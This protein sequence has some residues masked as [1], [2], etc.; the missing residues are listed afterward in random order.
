MTF[1]EARARV[2]HGLMPLPTERVPLDQAHGRALRMDVRAP[3]ALPPFANSAMDGIAVRAA[4]LAGASAGAPVTLAI[5]DTIAAGHPASR[6]LGAGQA[7]RIMTGAPLPEGA[8][9][10]VPVEDLDTPDPE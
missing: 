9:A 8:D 4:D 7:M 3:H 1:E 6:P 5:V 10:I 2:M